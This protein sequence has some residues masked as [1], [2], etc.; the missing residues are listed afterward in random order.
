ML[1]SVVVQ[2]SNP[3]TL[4]ISGA[5][6]DEML[7]LKSISGLTSPKVGLYLGDYSSE[8]SYYQGR[9]GE[10]LTPVITLKMNPNYVDDVDLSDIR[11]LLYRTFM[12][13]QPGSDGV[14]I[15]LK[16]DRRPDRY[17]VGYVE[18]IDTDQFSS[19][20]MATISMV[21]LEPVL[22]SD[23]GVAVSGLTTSTVNI[24]YDG[25]AP[26]GIRIHALTH[27][28]TTAIRISLNERTMILLK[29]SGTPGGWPPGTLVTINS[30]KAE[31]EVRINSDLSM[32]QIA[33]GFQWFQLDRPVN[34]L[35]A[36]G[37]DETL[38]D[39]TILDYD[40]KSTWWGV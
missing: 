13:P 21:S 27:V 12:T 39:V 22:F 36:L 30:R 4:N 40:F 20:R 3:L 28:Q 14:K 37:E 7:L 38:G 25:S 2:S 5:N 8:G 31:R 10:R 1:E 11:D 35:K 17:F 34:V 19:S 6:P 32:P 33:S 29:A 18:D 24:P 16:D 23:V 9:R 15:L 26:A